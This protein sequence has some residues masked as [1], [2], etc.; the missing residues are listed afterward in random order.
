METYEKAFFKKGKYSDYLN[1][2]LRK[3]DALVSPEVFGFIKRLN[4]ANH[5]DFTKHCY[6]AGKLMKLGYELSPQDLQFVKNQ[7]GNSSVKRED[8]LKYLGSERVKRVG[9]YF[10]LYKP[11]N[12]SYPTAK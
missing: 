8:L 11:V 4:G 3:I 1:N 5:I 10:V 2:M 9:H 6:V 12:Y 7:I